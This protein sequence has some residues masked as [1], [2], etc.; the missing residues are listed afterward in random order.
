MRR[1]RGNVGGPPSF[2]V[3]PLVGHSHKEGSKIVLRSRAATAST[4]RIVANCPA[5]N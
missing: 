5:K 3:A 4:V 2:G 1:V